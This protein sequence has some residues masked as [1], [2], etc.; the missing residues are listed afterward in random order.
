ML[1]WEP[2]RGAFPERLFALRERLGPP[3][4]AHSR[5]FAPDTPYRERHEFVDGEGMAFPSGPGVFEALDNA[6][7]WGIETDEQ[8]RYSL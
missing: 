2:R 6:R 3:L 4:V 8:D 7:E 1:G 5:W